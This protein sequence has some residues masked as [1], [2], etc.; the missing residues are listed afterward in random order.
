MHCFIIH[1]K[2]F[3]VEDQFNI[4]VNENLI[5]GRFDAVFRDESSYTIIDF[6]TG[7]RRDYTSQLSFY[8]LCFKEKYNPTKEIKLAVYYMKEG[9]LELINANSERRRIRKN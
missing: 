7:D 4:S 3:S 6:K 5:T 1:L 2:V 9:V 8:N